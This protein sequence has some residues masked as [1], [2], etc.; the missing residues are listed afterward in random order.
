MS[1]CLDGEG[2]SSLSPPVTSLNEAQRAWLDEHSVSADTLRTYLTR[3]QETRRCLLERGSSAAARSRIG[4]VVETYQMEAELHAALRQFS[5]AFDAYEDGLSFVR[6]RLEESPGG[7]DRADPRWPARLYQQEAYLHY[8]LGDLSASIGHYLSAFETAADPL[9]RIENLLNIGILHQRTQ[10]YRSAQHYFQRAQDRLQKRSLSGEEQKQLRAF[11]ALARADLLLEKSI[12]TDFE[13]GA[14]E[15]TQ[16]LARR[17]R[18]LAGAGTER[19]ARASSVLAESLGYLGAIE[20]AYRFSEEVLAYAQEHDDA[21]LRLI[22]LLKRGVLH[23]KSERWGLA[24]STLQ[25]ALRQAEELE[26]LDYQRRVLQALGRLHE[27]Q[28]NWEEAEHL[29]RQGISVVEEYRESLTASQWSMTAFAQWREVHRGLVRSLL[30]QGH[31]REAFV[32]LDRSRARHLQDLRTQAHVSRRLPPNERTRLDSLS[33]ALTDVRNQLG[34]AS[35]AAGDEAAL[36]NQEARL[37]AARQQLLELD[38]VSTRPGLGAISKSLAEQDRVLVSY[39]LDDPWPAYDRTPRSVAFILTA[40]SLQTVPLPGLTQDSVQAQ[41]NA[42]SPLFTS[43]GKPDRANSMHFDLRPLHRLH[44]AVYAPIAK[45]LSSDRPLTIIPDGPLFHLPFSM[46]VHSMPGGRFKPSEARFVLH[47]RPTSQELAS[48]LVVHD[49]QQSFDW[50]QFDP[51]MAAYGVS[52]FD[53]LRTV[54]SALRA[55]IPEAVTDSSIALPSL[56]GVRRELQALKSTVPD[57]QVSLNGRATERSFRESVR[58]AG[59]LHMASH[60]FVNAASPLQNAILLRPGRARSGGSG[61]EGTGPPSANAGAVSPDG[62]LFLHELQGQ[63]SRIP[64]VVL[65]GCNTA[66]GT[67]RGGEGMEGL[68]YAFRAMGAQSTVSTLWPVADQAS[69]ELMEAFYQ[70]LQDGHPKDVALRKAQ[71]A[72][73]N[74][75]PQ[76]SSPFFWAPPVLYGS[77][78]VLPLEGPALPAWMWWGGML[79]LLIVGAGGWVYFRSEGETAAPVLFNR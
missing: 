65:S 19:Y 37:M 15:R 38:S 69:V 26:D 53:T 2:I 75:H 39:F 44:D 63:Q 21:R 61:G 12:N 64:M 1:D 45:T 72:F 47:D 50:A 22:A 17:A 11:T 46:L 27:I 68:Q 4:D 70:N 60:A 48:S 79:V 32:T 7:S 30:A 40:D 23:M 58:S 43:R 76:K 28:G 78:T 9:A 31:P 57:A 56:P 71:L 10:D 66:S 8:L 25:T 13:R 54:P 6:T 33:R 49:T 59:V 36:R 67:L 74:A 5:R 16:A 3:V 55:S 29:Y 14:L 20:E 35:P 52:D 24:D 42:V 73:L 77:P 51:Q 41:V 18:S 62:V 34:G